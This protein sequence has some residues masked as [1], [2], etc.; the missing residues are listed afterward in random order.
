MKSSVEKTI[1]T[2][3]KEVTVVAKTLEK[4]GFEAYLIGGCARDLLLKK[5]P[6]DW[7]FT[8][9][10]TPEE[11]MKIFTNTFYENEYGT[12]G[13]V[14]EEVLDETLKVVEVTPYRLEAKY[15]NKRH[16]DAVTFGKKLDEDLKR[17]D[18]TINAIALKIVNPLAGG[19]ASCE[20][21][22]VDFFG[23]QKDLADKI[24][25]AVGEPTARFAEDALRI[26]RAIRLSA[27][28]DFS[29]EEKTAEAIKENA[30]HLEN[31]SSERIRDE[32]SRILLSDNPRKALILSHNLGILPFV[33][34][35]LEKGIGIK[36]N[37]AH[38]YDVWEH[39]LRTLQHAAKR[40]FAF[41]VRLVALLHDLGK[42]PARR[43]SEEKRDW[44]FYGHD[45]VG[46]K[47]ATKILSRL[48]FS[49]KITDDV[50]KLVRWHMFFSDTE[51]ITLSSVRRMIRN[52]G[53]ENIWKLMDV[54]AAD[55]IGTGRPKESPYRLRKYQAMVEEA[56]RD[57]V[58]VSML[59]VNGEKI[60]T[61]TN[62]EPGP[63][64]GFI[65]HA[66]LEEVL[67][68]PKLNTAD[69]L[70]KRVGEL[71]KLSDGELK[72]IGQEAKDKKAKEE[73][74]IIKEI[75]DKYWV[76]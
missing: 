30:R 3:P 65:L 12:V 54:R 60:M 24:I 70:E 17:R 56:S 29:I 73:E 67:E 55:R 39:S 45:V 4:A 40:N 22:M 37:S 43:W 63:K 48:K 49:K 38:S 52:V 8:T 76:K 19:D 10:A 28:L 47:I 1:F 33:L 31:I 25:R 51:V 23:G 46:A 58:S 14:N 57:P 15:S 36:Q 26:L 50:V 59:K 11:I 75:R 62:L 20:V 2:I 68:D 74:K 16:P 66:L 72:K 5:K 71:A 18:F 53:Q 35:E 64:I 27:E 69:Y 41:E 44:T 42:I 6:K 32:F 21:I 13:V 34:P 61:L 9:N 7:D